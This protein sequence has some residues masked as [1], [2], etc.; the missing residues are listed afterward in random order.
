MTLTG[1]GTYEDRDP[2]AP[3]PPDAS[4]LSAETIESLGARPEPE[5]AGPTLPPADA[6]AVLLQELAAYERAQFIDA[7]SPMF[8]QFEEM[9]IERTNALH[10]PRKVLALGIIYGAVGMLLAL[11]MLVVIGM[12]FLWGLSQFR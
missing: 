3:L 4:G 6:T 8:A 10:D 9:F 2:R 11:L 5:Y 12:L 7:M 1:S